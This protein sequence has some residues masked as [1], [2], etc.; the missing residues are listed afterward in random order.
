VT[1]VRPPRF[2]HRPGVQTKTWSPQSIAAIRREGM[3][4]ESHPSPTAPEADIKTFP[5]PL[6]TERTG[7]Y[8]KEC[9]FGNFQNF[10]ELRFKMSKPGF[11][12]FSPLSGKGVNTWTDN[13]RVHTA[14]FDTHT[15]L[16]GTTM[17]SH[18]I[19]FICGDLKLNLSNYIIIHYFF[20]MNRLL[21]KFQNCVFIYN[22][23]I[24]FEKKKC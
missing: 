6:I 20:F 4:V 16:V 21:N 3:T 8:I 10:W 11:W 5:S 23:W 17:I 18:N 19:V 15:T 13:L 2:L 22:I 9:V 24:N 12:V 7:D 1:G 14:G